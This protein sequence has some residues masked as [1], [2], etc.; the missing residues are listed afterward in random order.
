MGDYWQIR[1]LAELGHTSLDLRPHQ[2]KK[3]T[4]LLFFVSQESEKCAAH[5]TIPGGILALRIVLLLGA[6]LQL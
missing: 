4:S 5:G 3:K 2:K 6:S 1:A